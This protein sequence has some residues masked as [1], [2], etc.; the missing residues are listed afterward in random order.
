RGA[1]LGAKHDA[2]LQFVDWLKRT[3]GETVDA[4]S[5]F[6]CQIKRIHEYKRQLL[7]ALRIVVLY[8]RLRENPNL[9]IPPRTFFFSGKAAPAYQLAQVIIKFINNLAGI[10]DSDPTMR[11]R[12]KILFLP[13]YCVA[14]TDRPI[15]ASD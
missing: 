11:G 4:H 6:D 15:P 9:K 2:K 1:F 14:L 8:N 7:N 13:G 12:L 3:T 10:I 5:I